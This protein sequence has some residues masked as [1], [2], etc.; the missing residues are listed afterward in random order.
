MARISNLVLILT[1]P[2]SH[3]PE[4][5]TRGW[6]LVHPFH[7]YNNSPRVAVRLVPLYEPEILAEVETRT[8]DV[9]TVKVTLVAPVGTVTL[10]G[11]LAALLLQESKTC[12]PPGGAGPLSVTVAV[13][14]P[15][16]PTTLVGFSVNEDTVGSGTVT[17]SMAALLVVL[18]AELETI[19]L[20]CAP[21]SPVVVAGVV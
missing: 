1:Y 6:P 21:L 2:H 17:V 3:Q 10:A 9:L 12:A 13:E 15:R 19:T 11:T 5:P 8:I 16:P 18:P 20:N 7:R 4:Q 14:D